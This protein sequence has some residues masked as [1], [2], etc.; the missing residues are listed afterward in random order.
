MAFKTHFLS[1]QIDT[2]FAGLPFCDLVSASALVGTCSHYLAA[3]PEMRRLLD[4]GHPIDGASHPFVDPHYLNPAELAA[5]I[6]QLKHIR[7]TDFK[8]D[9]WSQKNVD[10]FIAAC[11]ACMQSNTAMIVAL[12]DRMSVDENGTP[13]HETT[14][15]GI[16]M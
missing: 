9:E 10:G 2:L 7:E 15:G 8:D 11:S 5:T 3:H 4:E 6:R 16:S 1:I 12:N 13:I 14:V